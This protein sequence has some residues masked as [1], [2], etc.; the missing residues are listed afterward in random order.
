MIAA[1]RGRVVTEAG[2]WLLCK[3]QEISI[4]LDRWAEYD[5]WILRKELGVSKQR[6]TNFDAEMGAL[7]YPGVECR[8]HRGIR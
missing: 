7:S 8:S 4:T 6:I 2:C 1:T 5:C 3:N